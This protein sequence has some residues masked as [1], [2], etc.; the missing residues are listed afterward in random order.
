MTDTEFLAKSEGADKYLL[1]NKAKIE[2]I[3]AEKKKEKDIATT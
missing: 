3:R 2:K 1:R